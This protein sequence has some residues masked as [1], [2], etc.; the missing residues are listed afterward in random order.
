MDNLISTLAAWRQGYAR[1]VVLYVC[2]MVWGV[3]PFAL[4]LDVPSGTE[5]NAAQIAQ[6]LKLKYGV[7]EFMLEEHKTFVGVLMPVR[8]FSITG[9]FQPPGEAQGQ[10]F[11][12]EAA[13]QAFFRAESN[14]LGLTPRSTMRKFRMAQDERGNTHLRFNHY[15]DGIRLYGTEALV[16]FTPDGKISDMSMG[17]LQ[18][19]DALLDALKQPTLSERDVR[20][21]V[22]KTLIARGFDIRDIVSLELEK[23]AIALP[24]YL[25]WDTQVGLGGSSYVFDAFTGTILSEK[26]NDI[27]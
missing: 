26:P 20:R 18:I 21:L 11:D 16:N 14:L 15:L 9:P 23:V 6:Y 7:Q 27:N 5:D 13:A 25:L 3:V 19:T 4:A 2:L 12:P 10:A 22:K 24:P 8:S 17:V 1:R